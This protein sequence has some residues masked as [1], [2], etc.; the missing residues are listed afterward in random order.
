MGNTLAEAVGVAVQED[1]ARD[2]LPVDS[3][4]QIP[5]EAAVAD[6]G[7]RS[8]QGRARP[9][10]AEIVPQVLP[11]SGRAAHASI[12]RDVSH[13][14]GGAR[15]EIHLELGVVDQYGAAVRQRRSNVSPTVGSL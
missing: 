6:E 15:N 5:A 11:I 14:R 9:R 12:G 1:V 13:R 7:V 2:R 8:G 10:R 3:G 4:E